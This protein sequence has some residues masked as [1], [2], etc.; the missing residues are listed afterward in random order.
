MGTHHNPVQGAEV[1]GVAVIG[2]LLNGTL[3]ALVCVTIHSKNL[4]HLVQQYYVQKGC[5]PCIAFFIRM[6]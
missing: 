5:N 1:L 3:N 2:T 4:L 6:W